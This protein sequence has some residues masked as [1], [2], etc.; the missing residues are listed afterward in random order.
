[1]EQNYKSCGGSQ[2]QN[3]VSFAAQKL[4]LQAV[5]LHKSYLYSCNFARNHTMIQATLSQPKLML[6]FALNNCNLPHHL[7]H[8]I[9]QCYFTPVTTEVKML[10]CMYQNKNC[11]LLL[12]RHTPLPPHFLHK[13]CK[14]IH[15]PS[16]FLPTF[17]ISG[18]RLPAALLFFNLSRAISTSSWPG[19]APG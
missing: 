17:N 7:T 3:V 1:M 9:Q 12:L 16:H 5:T 4:S 10:F 18:P 19:T 8:C 11:T 13:N 14:R 15:K 2:R 6:E